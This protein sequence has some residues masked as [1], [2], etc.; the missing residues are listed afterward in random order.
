MN[1][2]WVEQLCMFKIVRHL[3]PPHFRNCGT[4][5]PKCIMRRGLTGILIFGTFMV[6]KELLLWRVR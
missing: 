2:L 1:E 5:L 6:N 3:R 4:A